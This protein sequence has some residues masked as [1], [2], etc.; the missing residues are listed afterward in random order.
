[1]ETPADSKAASNQRVIIGKIC[2]I[3]GIAGW[4]K[5]LSYTRPRENIFN[6][7]R[8]MVGRHGEWKQVTLLE[9]RQQGK[10][11]VVR[12]EHL[13]DRDIARQY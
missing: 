11:L 7:Q 2:G 6:Y 3:Y 5:I 4:L 10:G 13:S 12:L 1:M 9:G 8:V